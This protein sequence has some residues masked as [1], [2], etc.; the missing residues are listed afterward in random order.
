M[1]ILTRGEYN[2]LSDFFNNISVAWFTGGIVAPFF[3]KTFAVEKMLFLIS[4]F[5]L[6]YL[7]LNLSLLFAREAR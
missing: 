6:S 7:F 3:S 4:G 5:G 1:R 2:V